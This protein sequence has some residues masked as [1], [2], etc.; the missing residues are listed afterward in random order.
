V[1]VDET[2]A[3]SSFDSYKIDACVVQTLLLKGF[4]FATCAE[5][6]IL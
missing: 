3:Q 6:S 4:S 2:V 5:F 1:A